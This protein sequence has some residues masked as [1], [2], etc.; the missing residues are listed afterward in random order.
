M[1]LDKYVYLLYFTHLPRGFTH[2]VMKYDDDVTSCTFFFCMLHLSISNI[3]TESGRAYRDTHLTVYLYYTKCLKS[4]G[5]QCSIAII[6]TV[7]SRSN[8]TQQAFAFEIA[9]SIPTV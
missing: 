4:K 9:L 1:I 7:L 8:I 5:Y 3:P 2:A 6:T